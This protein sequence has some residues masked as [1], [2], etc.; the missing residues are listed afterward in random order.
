MSEWLPSGH[1]A[2]AVTCLFSVCANPITHGAPSHV[3][4][5]TAVL[6]RPFRAPTACDS[7]VLAA[8]RGETVV[9]EANYAQR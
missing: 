2:L 3:A 1:L 9:K 7:V 6:R 8:S 4:G 5:R